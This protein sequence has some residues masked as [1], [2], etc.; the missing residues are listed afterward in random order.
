M[1]LSLGIKLVNVHRILKHKQSDW[2]KKYIDFNAEK[3][4]NGGNSFEKM[5]FKLMNKST[6]GKAVENLRK[7]NVRSVN[8]AGDYKKYVSKPSFVPQKTFSKKFCCYSWNLTTFKTDKPIY[9]RF[10]IFDLSRL[11]M[12]EFH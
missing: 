1:Y 12:H 4:K 3:R 10:S 5:F 8:N 11:S 7:K 6:F 2:L 9:V